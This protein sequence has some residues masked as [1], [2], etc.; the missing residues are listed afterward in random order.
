MNID[1][2]QHMAKLQQ[3]QIPYIGTVLEAKTTANSHVEFFFY[4]FSRGNKSPVN[5][6]CS[7]VNIVKKLCEDGV[8]TL[9]A[10]SM[11]LLKDQTNYFDFQTIECKAIML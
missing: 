11:K 6:K 1:L 9:R 3:R 2:I 4:Y 10:K 7:K 8:I 5:I